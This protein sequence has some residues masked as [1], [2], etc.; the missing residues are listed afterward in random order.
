MVVEGKLLMFFYWF[1]SY[2]LQLYMVHTLRIN[3]FLAFTCRI[4]ISVLYSFIRA[5]VIDRRG[6]SSEWA[7]LIQ[8]NKG[9][10]FLLSENANL[11]LL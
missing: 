7:T 11:L 8:T 3:F 9:L 10:P 2:L 6:K 4:H 1:Y 5:P